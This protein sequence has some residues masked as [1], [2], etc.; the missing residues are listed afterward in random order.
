MLHQRY[1][2]PADKALVLAVALALACHANRGMTAADIQ[3]AA[4][5]LCRTGAPL[6]YLSAGLFAPARA[7][8]RS[9]VA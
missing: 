3:A 9:L 8:V 6:E 5:L 7:D 1:P 4:M 2:S